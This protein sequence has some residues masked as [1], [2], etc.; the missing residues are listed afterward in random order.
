MK[1]LWIGLLVIFSGYVGVYYFL[2]T[3]KDQQANRYR[4]TGLPDNYVF[5][6][7]QPV[8][9]LNLPTPQHGMLNAL[10]FKAPK[11]KGVICFWK[12]NGGTLA[13]WGAIAHTFLKLNYD[14]LLTDYR[15]HGKSKGPITLSNF[16]TD[17]QAVYDYLKQ[18][19]KESDIIICGYSLGGRVAAHLAAENNPRFTLLLDPASAGGDFSDRFT[20]SLYYPLP[21]VNEFVFPTER[22]VQQAKRPVIVVSTAN[23][24]S[25]AYGL[26]DFITPKD[27]FIVLPEVT[28]ETILTHPKTA[29]LIGHFLK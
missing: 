8:V 22:D 14:V 12:G 28:H 25:V 27:Q 3:N 1:W 15:Q 21:S 19:Y 11:P 18:R 20:D 7:P 9:E 26:S 29:Q 5:S 24:K 4:S 10:L 23:T 6:F 2:Y 16:Y 17:A 13:N